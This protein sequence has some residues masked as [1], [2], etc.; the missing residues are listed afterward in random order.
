MKYHVY[1]LILLI[2]SFMSAE[3]I[4]DLYP[5]EASYI[6]QNGEDGVVEKLFDIIKPTS[7]YY[8]EFGA[9]DGHTWSNT[10]YFREKYGWTGL[11]MDCKDDVPSLNLHKEYITALNINNLFDKYRV[12]EDVDL[13]S[14]D[15]DYN[16]FY[17][18][19]ALNYRP[20][21][22]IVE[23]NPTF[24]ADEDKV[25]EFDP[26]GKSGP[27]WYRSASILAFSELAKR[28]GYLLVYRPLNSVNLIFVREDLIPDGVVFK[29]SDNLEKI[30][31]QL[32][33]KSK[34]P[35]Y[36]KFISSKEAMEIVDS[37]AE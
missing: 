19:Y 25:I 2:N 4:I 5:F 6:S 33:P 16:D 26:Y 22:I 15:I 18:F 27:F 28:K 7:K 12:P 37:L 29:N 35:I 8:V 34:F 31:G 11:L 10:K 14:I 9:G 32:R 1:I 36:R 24:S 17:V 23:F 13:L 3:Q 20:K 21:V 30:L